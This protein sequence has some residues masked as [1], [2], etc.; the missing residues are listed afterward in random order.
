MD[1]E[2]RIPEGMSFCEKCIR[3][4][5]QILKDEI[6]YYADYQVKLQQME[7]KNSSLTSNETISDAASQMISDF[8]SDPI[9]INAKTL[10]DQQLQ[11]DQN[12]SNLIDQA[13]E[14]KK[15]HHRQITQINLKEK[16]LIYLQEQIKEARTKADYYERKITHMKDFSVFNEVF[17]IEITTSNGKINGMELGV[18]EE[19]NEI[20]WTYMNTSFGNIMNIYLYLIKVD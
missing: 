13:N 2:L 12:V 18:S 17:E 8:E 10:K 11:M 9:E 15:S 14:L 7:A 3:F 19:S 5:I 16:E 20:N 6:N 1:N 4:R